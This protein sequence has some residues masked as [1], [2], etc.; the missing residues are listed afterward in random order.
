MKYRKFMAMTILFLGMTSANFTSTFA[1]ETDIHKMETANINQDNIKDTR[2]I[3]EYYYRKTNVK[4][5]SEWSPYKRVSDTISVNSRGGSISSTKTQ[6]FD[7][8]ISGSI[9][10]INVNIGKSLSSAKGYIL[11]AEPNT[12]VYMG[13][14]V[15]YS[16]E[17]GIR[18]KVDMVTGRVVSSNR[19]T[20]KNP[21]NG[22]Y[23]LLK[24]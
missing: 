10:N 21:V 12:R 23:K 5:S 20:V 22:E 24:D 2:S 6:K 9:A 13:Y 4:T 14:R 3:N 17:T 8:V 15:K 1:A 11:H 16:V 18:E 7:V 19:Y